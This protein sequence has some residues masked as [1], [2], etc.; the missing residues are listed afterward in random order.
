VVKSDAFRMKRAEP[1]ATDTA[2]KAEKAGQP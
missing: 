1:A 2:D